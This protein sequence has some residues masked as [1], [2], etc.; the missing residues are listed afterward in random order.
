MTTDQVPEVNPAGSVS[1]EDD[2]SCPD[3][4]IS[5]CVRY[6]LGEP[7]PCPM[8]RKPASFAPR[9][10]LRSGKEARHG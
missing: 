6:D 1:V 5:R 2:D 9:K 8:G 4:P 10:V 3:C 7:R